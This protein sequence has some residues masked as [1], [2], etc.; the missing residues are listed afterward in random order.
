MAA[1]PQEL[2]TDRRGQRG[3]PAPTAADAERIGAMLEGVLP[4]LLGGDGRVEVCDIVSGNVNCTYKVKYAGRFL[5]VRVTFNQYRFK[6]EKN[7]IKEIFAIYL[8]Y[9][10]KPASND[11]VARRIVDGILRNSVGSHINHSLVRSIVRY[12][13][14]LRTLPYPFFVYEWIEGDAL[15]RTGGKDQYFLAGRDLARLHQISFQAYYQDIFNIG[16]TPRSWAENFT[17]SFAREL[18]QARAR[19]PADVLAKVGALDVSRMRPGR[20]ALVHND[21]A[22]GNIIVDEAG[23]RK[24]IDWDNWLVESPELDLL[25]MKYWTAIG[26]DGLLAHDPELYAAFLAGYRSLETTAIDEDLLRA[27]EV[28]WLMRTFNFESAKRED[29]EISP[30]GA[31]WREHYPPAQAYLDHLRAL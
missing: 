28:L 25:K 26:E 9:Y 6:Y 16:R 30:G 1:T 15:W 14:S 20:P 11:A 31:S 12:D 24:I 8:I 22:G 21:Y 23:A 2:P 7:I 13:W 19:L 17:L 3:E 18:A 5:G 27:Y 29:S 4:Q 10:S